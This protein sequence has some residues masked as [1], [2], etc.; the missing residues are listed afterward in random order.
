MNRPWMQFAIGIVTLIA[1]F[2][3][4]TLIIWFGEFQNVLQSKRVY[5]VTFTN[6]LGA[7]PKVPVRRAGMRIGDIA[8]VEYS[9]A[10][11]LVV[12]TIQLEGD[13]ALRVG[14]EPRM[15]RNIIGGDVYLDI[16]TRAD[17]RGK[18]DRPIIPAKSVIEGRPP[19]DF[20]A[21]AEQA[22]TLAPNANRTMDELQRTSKEWTDV[23]IR[24]N[25]LLAQNERD[26]NQILQQTRESM[27]KLNTTLE[28]INNTLDKKTQDNLRLTMDN[29]AKASTDLN[30][31]IESA[32]KS[33]KQITDTTQ[34]LDEVAINLQ[35]TTK[36]LA[37][38]SES[39]AKNLDEA[40]RNLNLLAQD[41][42][43]IARRFQTNDGTLQRLMDD[44]KLYQN[45]DQAAYTLARTLTE[46]DVVMKDLKVFADKIARHPGELGVQG[47]LTRDQGV[48]HVPPS[49]LNMKSGGVFRR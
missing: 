10:D 34:K 42:G 14:D 17:L 9:E 29:L 32:N 24:A 13:N 20:S 47:V 11:S 4:G 44:P 21:T 22:A 40:T 36:P 48:K 38:R 5:Y 41:M 27:E 37:E 49:E 46:L 7:E 31:L 23:G 28:S 26:I 15:N 35:K 45:L 12:V 30:P 16:D 39:T 25:R 18:P 19:Q 33:I 2:A 1:L 8:K 43:A 3:L 6:A